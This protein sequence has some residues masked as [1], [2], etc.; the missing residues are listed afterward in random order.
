MGS[1]AAGVCA[2]PVGEQRKRPFANR[3]QITPAVTFEPIAHDRPHHPHDRPGGG[4]CVWAHKLLSQSGSDRPLPTRVKLLIVRRE[5]RRRCNDAVLREPDVLVRHVRCRRRHAGLPN[6]IE[7]LFVPSQRGKFR[8]KG[9]EMALLIREERRFLGREIPK[10]R[11]TRHA[12]AS[13]DGFYGGRVVATVCDK[14][15]NRCRDVGPGLRFFGV[16]DAH[17]PMVQQAGRLIETPQALWWRMFDDPSAQTATEYAREP[18]PVR[19]TYSAAQ[20]RTWQQLWSRQLPNLRTLAHSACLNGLEHAGFSADRIASLRD[21]SANLERHTGWRLRRVEGLVPQRAFFELVARRTFPATDFIRRPEDLDYTPAPDLFHDQFGHLPL[22]TLPVYARFFERFGE[23]GCRA[24]D[25]QVLQLARI[26]WF[27]VE[28]GLVR[29]NGER[30]AFGAGLMS[31]IG[32]LNNAF[33]PRTRVHKL[34]MAAIA[35]RPF[36][37]TQIQTDYFEARDF[38]ELASSFDRWAASQ[39]L[40]DAC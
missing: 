1:L 9:V 39:G 33:A 16:A 29:E 18:L 13:C 28:F 24:N 4:S 11:G 23:A 10:E 30:K 17:A 7:R 12:R 34:D 25:D 19:P 3:Q 15:T 40:V 36:V 35:A 21:L 2:Q 27:T 5:P 31:S 22:L 6:S 20:E 32:E 14:A 38:E 8:F 26:Y 37:T